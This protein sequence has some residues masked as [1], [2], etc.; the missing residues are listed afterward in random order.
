[1]SFT[2]SEISM[3]LDEIQIQHHPVFALVDC[4]NFYASCERVFDPKL[5]HVPIVVLS[6][7]DGCVIARSNEAKRLGIQMGEPFFKCKPIIDKHGVK[8]FS[9]NFALYGDM[10]RRVMTVLEQFSPDQEIYSIDE[11]FLRLDRLAEIPKLYGSQIR[12][13]VYQWTGIPVSIG[14]ATT[15]TL[16]KAANRIA[17]KNPSLN[18]VMD[19]TQLDSPDTY[20]AQIDIEDIWGVGRQYAKMLR[21]YGITNALK[22]KNT[23]LKWI[24][25]HMTVMG[26]RMVMEMRGVSC[27]PLEDCPSPKKSIICSRTFGK[28]ITKKDDLNEALASFAARACEKLRRQHSVA[29]KIEIFVRT[30]AFESDYSSATIIGTV[31]YTNDTRPFVR[32]INR[33]LDEIFIRGL[34]YKKAGVMLLDIQPE[35]MAQENLFTPCSPVTLNPKLMNAM[36]RLNTE[37]GSG[38]V[39]LAAEGLR[40][41]WKMRQ[42]NISKRYTTR[43]GELASV[44]VAHFQPQIRTLDV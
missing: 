25:K 7:N 27:I 40:K 29:G 12:N 42:E 10:S 18:G 41:S 44:E 22:L 23:E 24:R 9:S 11:S 19:F 30:S 16:A 35:N 43:W 6:N 14:I 33:M 4:N 5:K 21:T 38:T 39:T 13:T 26:E 17:K 32:T 28:K 1:M 36:D 34:A 20:L 31:P 2:L 37:W 15:K 8:V 3:S